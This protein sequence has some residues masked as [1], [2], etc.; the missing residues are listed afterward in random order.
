MGQAV[1]WIA[2]RD[3]RGATRRLATCLVVAL[4]ALA[5]CGS[6][7]RATTHVRARAA[8]FRLQKCPAWAET[9]EVAVSGP[10]K[11]CLFAAAVE[12]SLVHHLSK[13]SGS[14][15]V[16]VTFRGKHQRLYCK[17]RDQGL[18]VTCFGRGRP[19]V[20]VYI[21]SAEAPGG[22]VDCQNGYVVVGPVGDQRRAY[23]NSVYGYNLPVYAYGH[24]RRCGIVNDLTATVMVFYYAHG[25]HWPSH[26]S[27]Q[28]GQGWGVA[29]VRYLGAVTVRLTRNF[30]G[31]SFD[32]G[33]A[34]SY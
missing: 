25:D 2:R 9:N 34:R 7:A 30:W 22:Y 19:V 31:V 28:A 3:Q 13:M 15:A 26:V 12:Q 16:P 5:T 4:A 8:S 18:E 21:D 33:R 20:R 27:D 32:L 23:V 11:G 14:E 6:A 10:A 17:I 29:V 24:Y 1:Q